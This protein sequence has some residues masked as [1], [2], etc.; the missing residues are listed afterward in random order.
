MKS[1]SKLLVISFSFFLLFSSCKKEY[2]EKPG[3]PEN[4]KYYGN[5]RFTKTNVSDS[6]TYVQGP[7]GA[8]LVHTHNETTEWEHTGTISKTPD[9]GFLRIAFT[10]DIEYS[11]IINNSNDGSLTCTFKC[12]TISNMAMPSGVSVH[13]LTE[14][15]YY[16]NLGWTT[17]SSST[18]NS[19]HI[20]GVKL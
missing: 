13:R 12:N 17:G 20:T 2:E 7:N 5:W 11:A 1:I 18:T 14:G 4:E 8:E 6:Y 3:N 10:P 16:V 19:S 15:E 9:Y